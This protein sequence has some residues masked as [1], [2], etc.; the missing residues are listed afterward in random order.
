MIKLGYE[1]K[2]DFNEVSSFLSRYNIKASTE[3]EFIKDLCFIEVETQLLSERGFCCFGHYREIFYDV[4][5]EIKERMEN[6]PEFSHEK[7]KELPQL[8]RMNAKKLKKL[9]LED[10]KFWMKFINDFMDNFDVLA[11]YRYYE[12]ILFN[13]GFVEVELKDFT[14]IHLLKLGPNQILKINKTIYLP[15]KH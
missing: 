1:K 11:L 2:H 15:Q 3:K 7:N 5:K 12:Y 6:D 9:H 10:L 13:T 8:M 14:D 4:E